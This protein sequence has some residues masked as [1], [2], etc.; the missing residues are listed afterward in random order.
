MSFK[1]Q[2]VNLIIQG[3][4]LFSA[5][6]KK[7]EQALQEL[8]RESE[9]LNEQ[10]DDLKRQQEAIKAI[11]SLTESINK[12]ERAYVDNAQALD[13]LKQEQKQANTEAKNLEKSQQDAAASTAKLETEYSQ[14]AAQLASY[15]SQLASARA[16]VERLTTT[17]NKGAQASQA[18][19]KAL[20]AAKTD[21][22]QLESAQKIPPPVRPSW[23][24]SL[25]K[26]VANS[27]A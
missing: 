19:A 11:D 15:D 16:E 17:Q 1:D 5:E 18:Q 4:D 26:N 13:K 25:S 3:K 6:A 7:S 23:Q 27:R 2:E 21:L 10:L 24:T 9:K 22:Q 14:T 8:G 20:S 12:G